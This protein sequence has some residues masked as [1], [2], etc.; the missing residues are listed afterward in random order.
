MVVHSQRLLILLAM[1][2][3]IQASVRTS[4]LV[5]DLASVTDTRLVFKHCQFAI[6]IFFCVHSVCYLK[7]AWFFLT[8]IFRLGNNKVHDKNLEFNIGSFH[9]SP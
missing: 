2:L 8:K 1:K 3:I 5:I 6:L 9:G 4:L 7:I